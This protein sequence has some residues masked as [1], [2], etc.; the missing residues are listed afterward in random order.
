MK[1]YSGRLYIVAVLPVVLVGAL[2][3]MSRVSGSGD[4]DL[5]PCIVEFHLPSTTDGLEPT[6][7]GST[8]EAVVPVAFEISAQGS[9][10]NL[11]VDAPTEE[12]GRFTSRFIKDSKYDPSCRGKRLIVRF[13]YRL[14]RNPIALDLPS[15]SLHRGNTIRMFFASQLPAA[16]TTIAPGP[17]TK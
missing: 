9:A 3:C 7:V 11:V 16:P 1:V 10:S 17:P 13:E 15:Y 5:M 14:F 8:N 4:V 2:S 12:L 6:W